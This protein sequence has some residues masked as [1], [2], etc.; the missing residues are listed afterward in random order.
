[1]KQKNYRILCACGCGKKRWKFDKYGIERFFISVKHYRHSNQ[2]KIK[3][4]P[5]PKGEKHWSW[6]GSNILKISGR[7]RA[8]KILRAVNRYSI[9][10][11]NNENCSKGRLEA[12]HID[13]NP[14]NNS[15]NNL[16]CLC[17]SHH[18]IADRYSSNISQLREFQCNIT[19]GFCGTKLKR[20][21]SLVAK[22]KH[23]YCNRIC[24]VAQQRTP[25]GRQIMREIGKGKHN[26]L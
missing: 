3:P 14:L 19:C 9:C 20:K 23:H 18:R 10:E 1:M 11:L 6:K 25:E 2:N 17:I 22:Y 13:R 16:A 21:P 5:F 8:R 7:K 4:G 24:Q 15:L 26:K 12:H